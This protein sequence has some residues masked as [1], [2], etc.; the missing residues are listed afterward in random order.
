MALLQGFAP[1]FTT[2]QACGSCVCRRFADTRIVVIQV[3]IGDTANGVLI[4]ASDVAMMTGG[5]AHSVIVV[6]A[7]T[8]RHSHGS[9]TLRGWSYASFRVGVSNVFAPYIASVHEFTL[10]MAFLDPL[11]HFAILKFAMKPVDISWRW[12]S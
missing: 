10:G 4:V 12:G 8:V 3:L 11:V 7:R 9:A 5:D 2:T 1:E 6:P